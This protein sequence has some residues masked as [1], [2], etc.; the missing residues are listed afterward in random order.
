MIIKN[1]DNDL[2][3]KS[4]DLKERKPSFYQAVWRWHFYAGLIFAPFIL[5]LAVTGSVYLF[6]LYPPSIWVGN[7]P[8]TTVKTKEIADVPW[9]AQN[10]EVPASKIQ[11]YIP[12]SIDDVVSIAN[13]LN[14]YPSYTV[15]FPKKADGVFTLSVFP[16]KAKDEGTVHIDQYTGAVLADYRYDNYKTIGKM[17][18]WGITVHKGL[19]YGLA[20]QLINLVVCMGIIGVV[21]SGF[22]LW[23]KR[24]P[25]D[26]LGAR[27]APDLKKMKGLV[28]ILILFGALFPLVGMSLIVV[29]LLD[30]L[31]IQRV[32]ALKKYL[33][34]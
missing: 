18:A 19:E 24:K 14:I 17:M 22:I 6:K 31:I 26:H 29:Y 16:P 20:N 28:I 33:N 15:I 4:S 5:I 2:Q 8:S 32:P 7:A 3:D 12:V 9:A 34:A 21:V 23:W 11:G 30:F 25:S 10:L 27:K 13:N 1:T